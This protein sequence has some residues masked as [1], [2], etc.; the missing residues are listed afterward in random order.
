MAR[1]RTAGIVAGVA[2]ATGAL[3]LFSHWAGRRAEQLAP[4]DG[5]FVEV[6][7]A[8]LHYVAIGEGPPIVLIHGLGGQLRNFTYALTERLPGHRLIAIDRPRSG[9]STVPGGVEPGLRDQADLI[10]AAIRQLGLDQPMLVGHSLGG[11]I[12]LALALDHPGLV[13][14]LALI[15]PLTQPQDDVPAAFRGIAAAGA[16]KAGRAVM[17]NLI[18]VPLGALTA[19][20]TTEAVFAPEPAP[21]DF[22]V[23]GGG[24][25][26]LRPGNIYAAIYDMHAAAQEIGGMAARYGELT[27]PVSILYAR[28][29]NILDYRPNGE[30]TA[31]AI[32]GATL[33]LVDGGHMLPVTQPD[34][35]AQFIKDAA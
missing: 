30:Q 20:A 17:A 13:R 28:E 25:L 6:D 24:A 34:V 32:P 35:T 15:A 26:A 27:L 7:G 16:S 3:A 9:Y 29:D 4:P 22:A 23:R 14:G 12:A 1:K 2:A 10:A 19:A 21:E 5:D 31:A 8:R 33:Q 18:A 11:A